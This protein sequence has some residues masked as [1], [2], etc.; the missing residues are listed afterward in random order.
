M[1]VFTQVMMNLTTGMSDNNKI[2]IEAARIKALRLTFRPQVKKGIR[3]P[4][5]SN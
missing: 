3:G 2:F 4:T 1:G 5:N